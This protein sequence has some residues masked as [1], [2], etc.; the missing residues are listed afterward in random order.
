[1]EYC[2][3]SSVGHGSRVKGDQPLMNAFI[4][5]SHVI[6]LRPLPRAVQLTSN[7]F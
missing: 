6:R 2:I 5:T 1:M 4:F 3:L 7:S